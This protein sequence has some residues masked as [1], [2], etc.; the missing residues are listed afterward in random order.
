MKYITR[1]REAGNEI[2]RFATEE[3]AVIA[4]GEYED[5]DRKNGDYTD[6]FYEVAEIE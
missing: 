1:D 6:G 2:E 5:E 4:V 3:E